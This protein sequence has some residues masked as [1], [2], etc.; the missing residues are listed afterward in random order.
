MQLGG[1]AMQE[2]LPDIVHTVVQLCIIF[3]SDNSTDRIS[4]NLNFKNF[5]FS[6][7]TSL[8]C[9]R[10]VLFKYKEGNPNADEKSG[11]VGKAVFLI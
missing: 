10:D 3:T 7:K 1:A 2:I 5:K 4:N 6:G 11:N 9:I 8:F